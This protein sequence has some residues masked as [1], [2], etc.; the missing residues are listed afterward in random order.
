MQAWAAMTLCMCGVIS[1]SPPQ[2]SNAFSDMNTWMSPSS[3]CWSSFG[4]LRKRGK[5]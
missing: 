2:G 5:S 4:R 3:S 1:S